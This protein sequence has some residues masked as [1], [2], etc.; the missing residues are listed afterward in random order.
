MV[1]DVHDIWREAWDYESKDRGYDKVAKEDFRQ[2]VRT[3]K[4]NPDGENYDWW[5]NNGIEFVNSWINWKRNSGWK[6]WETPNGDPAIELGLTPK[7][8]NTLVKLVLDRVMVNPE[9]ELIILDIKTGRNT[10]SSDL[11]LAFYAAG[12][13]QAFGIR[14]RWGTYWMARQGGTGVPLDLDLVPT[15]TVDYLIKEF[16]RAR[17]A[18][19]FI[20]NL[21]N[22]KMCSRTDYC[23]WRN[24][25][26]AHTI[27]EMN[28]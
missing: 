22:C 27:G 28:G 5:F 12:M 6:I 25:S 19:L 21:T 2:S 10:P 17:K 7:F 4:A 23:K 3:T 8:D 18:N 13:E 24:G 1:I 26:L 16:N 11:Q 14:P 15:S 9:G 20:P